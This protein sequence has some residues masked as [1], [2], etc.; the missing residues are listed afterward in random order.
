MGQELRHRR[1]RIRRERRNGLWPVG[2][3]RLVGQRVHHWEIRVH[4]RLRP[5]C[6]HRQPHIIGVEQR[7]LV[8]PVRG[9]RVCLE[10]GLIRQLRVGQKLYRHRQFTGQVGGGR[11][12]GQ[13][14][15]RRILRWHDRLRPGCGHRQPHL[16]RQH[17]FGHKRVCLKA[18]LI[19]QLRVGQKLYRHRQFTGRLGGGRFVGQHLH[20]R[21]LRGDDRL[22]P[23]CGHRQPHLERRR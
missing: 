1:P 5:G 21:I 22:R 4:G 8:L 11:L 7:K 2:D 16:E 12:V 9:R 14:V 6:G 20:R 10:A 3:G 15:H 23:G 17:Y 18:G 13:R 19:R